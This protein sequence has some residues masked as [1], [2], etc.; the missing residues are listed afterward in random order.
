VPDKYYLFTNNRYGGP[1][2]GQEIIIAVAA[3][4]G[5]LAPSI[6]VLVRDALLT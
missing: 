1:R 2:C 6:A 5:A 3:V 4:D